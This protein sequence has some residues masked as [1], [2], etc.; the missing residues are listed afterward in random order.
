MNTF[1]NCYI[2]WKL[3]ESHRESVSHFLEILHTSFFHRFHVKLKSGEA[4]K[5]FI[6]FFAAFIA[7]L[8]R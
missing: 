3:L 4:R 7:I 8:H 2:G 6:E 5:L 1:C